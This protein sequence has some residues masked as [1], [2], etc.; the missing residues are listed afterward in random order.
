[1]KLPTR[2]TA[3]IAA[4]VLFTTAATGILAYRNVLGVGLPG[5]LERLGAY[6]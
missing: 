6:V 1:V 5:S 4:L 2:L 3:A